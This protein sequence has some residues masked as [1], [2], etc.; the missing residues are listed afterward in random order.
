M[1]IVELDS[2][3]LFNRSAQAAGPEC[4]VYGFLVRSHGGMYL[5]LWGWAFQEKYISIALML[6]AVVVGVMVLS[7]SRRN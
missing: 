2:G 3:C 6:Q 5:R 7:V 1:Q 4:V